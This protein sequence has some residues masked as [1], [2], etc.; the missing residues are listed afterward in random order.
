MIFAVAKAQALWFG[1]LT[2]II[3]LTSALVSGSAALLGVY[4]VTAK[5]SGRNVSP[6]FVKSVGKLVLTLLFFD[7]FFVFW[8]IMV[9]SYATVPSEIA[10]LDAMLF[11]PFAWV[12]WIVEV[13]FG[14]LVPTI[15]LAHP[16][17]G[18]NPLAAM[19]AAFSITFGILGVRFNIVIPSLSLAPYESLQE[20]PVYFPRIPVEWGIS[21][22]ILA[23][24]LL[25]YS[26]GARILPLEGQAQGRSESAA[27]PSG[28]PRRGALKVVAGAA[29]AL[30]GMVFLG[31]KLQSEERRDE[32][33]VKQLPSSDISR[34]GLNGKRFGMI[35]DLTRCTGCQACAVACKAEN[36]VPEGLFR[37]WVPTLRWESSQM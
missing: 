16:R 7:W 26:I 10:G 5:L 3:F 34:E 21:I 12:F 11:G 24:P 23:L 32:V 6:D 15:L 2:P 31:L 25:V 27:T 36:R 28:L 9:I 17:T 14:L 18:K 29:V 1:P 30:A 4:I 13:G 35:I 8:E 33:K 20:V 22:G 19:F 37:R